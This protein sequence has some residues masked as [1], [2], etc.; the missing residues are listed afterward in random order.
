MTGVFGQLG[1]ALKSVFQWWIVIAPWEQALRVRRGKKVAYLRGG[2][3]LRLP[4]VDRFFIQSVRLRV[5]DLPIQT[6][7]TQDGQ[8][9]TLKGQLGYRILDLE[10][11]Y[12]TLHAAQATIINLAPME[13]ADYV[14]GH[15]VEECDPRHIASDAQEA[16][17]GAFRD[18]GLGNIRV[19]I[20][21]YARVKTYRLIT[22]DVWSEAGPM[23]DTSRHVDKAE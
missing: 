14:A 7:T 4:L 19:S 11:L 22:Q 20:T 12:N 18:Y 3:H 16:L 23:L 8:T 17:Q 5:A 9:I 2:I 1:Q 10:R 15:Q 13:I 21:D 6:V